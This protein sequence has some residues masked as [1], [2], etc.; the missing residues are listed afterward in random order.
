MSTNS[1]LMQTFHPKYYP[2][3]N[4]KRARG[5]R[6]KHLWYYN[7]KLPYLTL[8]Y[9]CL[10]KIITFQFHMFRHCNK[11]KSPFKATWDPQDGRG[12]VIGSLM[13]AE[14]RT[15]RRVCNFS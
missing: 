10:T 8:C 3:V 14:C 9:K 13:L 4:I 7:T 12:F 5:K 15:R 6:H 2:F 1:T 11:K